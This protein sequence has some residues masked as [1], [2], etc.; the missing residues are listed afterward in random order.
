MAKTKLLYQAQ[1]EMVGGSIKVSTETTFFA[2]E[3]SKSNPSARRGEALR[4]NLVFYL[5][6]LLF[7][8]ISVKYKP[9]RQD[10]I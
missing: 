8:F 7:V 9:R 5:K 3:D 1:K 2:H 4:L 6:S 10:L